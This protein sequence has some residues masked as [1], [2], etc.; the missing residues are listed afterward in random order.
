MD[1]PRL[2]GQVARRRLLLLGGVLG[3]LTLVAPATVMAW[4]QYDDAKRHALSEL[5]ARV[6][7]ASTVFDVYFDGQLAV[8]RSIAKSPTVASGDVGAMTAYFRRVQPP[9][10]KLFPAGLGWID[11]RGRVRA[12][13]L[14]G[15][16]GQGLS[17]SRRDYFGKTVSTRRP[18]I[19]GGL[20]ARITHR[21]L[22]VLAVPTLSHGRVTGVLTGGLVL[23]PASSSSAQTSLGYQG[24]VVIDRNGR[25]LTL[26]SLAR[27][28]NEALVARMRG[29]RSGLLADTNGLDGSSGRVVAYA[30]SAGP[31]WISVIDRSSSSV[32][33]SARR[34]LLLELLSIAMAGLLILGLLVWTYRRAGRNAAREYLRAQVASELT[35]ALAVA[36][37]PR[38][39]AQALATALAAGRPHTLV[40]VALEA[41]GRRGLELA[42][43]RGGALAKLDRTRASLLEPAASAGSDAPFMVSGRTAVARR[44]PDLARDAGGALEGVYTV[45]LLAAGGL[46]L[47]CAA[48][49]LETPHSLG[50]RERIEIRSYVDQA[51]PVLARTRRQE[52]EHLVAV[53]LQRSLLP[54]ELPERDNLAFASRYHAG[55]VGVEVGGD[56]YDALRRPDGI[57]HV[58]VGDVAGRGIRAATLMA[59]LR[60]AFRA[61]ALDHASPAA[62]ILRLLRHVPDGNMVTTACLA[63][64]PYTRRYDYSLAGH[65]PVL[66]L[67][68]ASGAV[69][70]L[71]DASAPP[72]GFASEDAI[73]EGTGMLAGRSTLIAYTDGLVERR[74]MSIEDGIARVAAILS[75]AQVETA[76]GLADAILDAA[77]AGGEADDDTA[78]LIV[79]V[80]EVPPCVDIEVPADPA[81][82][83]SLRRRLRAWMSLRGIP[84]ADQGDAV[85]SVHEACT[86]AIEHGYG[87][88]GG[89]IRILAEHEGDALRILIEDH[90]RWRPPTPDPSRGFGIRLMETSMHATR[91]EHGEEGTAVRLELQLGRAEAPVGGT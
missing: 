67:D 85:L 28:R 35:G 84:D 29:H 72:L 30:T 73:R 64:D 6:A 78:F 74:G 2:D 57:V 80:G 88:A 37:T 49:L 65:P 21:R 38:A 69:T 90:G 79:E 7:L 56:W 1:R 13:T 62:V 60:N 39:V 40:V 14:P 32:F 91:I 20:V 25:E 89:T 76:D 63:L 77:T 45:P 82:L 87:M 83:A 24:L 11:L 10:G 55:G 68:R 50:E 26:R 41:E 46:G 3:V 19:S 48:L 61:Y 53:E 12:S 8:L 86:N 18:F 47:G 51:T 33:A 58:S 36:A 34:S 23:R 22:I 4:R 9:G 70:A 31:R 71:S 81:L 75:S 43:V 59:Q 44:F 54:D 66:V 16:R 17:V 27:P 42:A 5:G 15:G 52:R